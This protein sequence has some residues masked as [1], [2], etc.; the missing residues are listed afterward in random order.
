MQIVQQGPGQFTDFLSGYRKSSTGVMRK[1]TLKDLVL[2][3]AA[4]LSAMAHAGG[5]TV[6]VGME[7]EG[8]AR[9]GLFDPK[10]QHLFMH[11]L[12]ASIIPPLIFK[13]IPQEIERKT[14]LKLTVSPSAVVHLLKNKKCYLRV[15]GQNVILSREK[16]PALRES[17]VETWHERE[18]LLNSSLDDLDADLVAEFMHHLGRPGE[19]ERILHRPYGL[20][21]YRDGQP[22]LTRAAAYLF[23][24]DP[25]RWHPRPGVEF[26]RFEGNEK[27]SGS[28]YNVAERLRIE[29]PIMKLIGEMERIMEARIKERVILRDLFFRE[30]FAYPSFAWRE[31]LTNA[32]AHRDYSLEGSAVEVWMFDDRLE[33]R[34]PGR[35]PGPVK[36]QQLLRQERAHYS[37]NPLISRVLTDRGIMRSMGEG[38]SR[39]FREM[40]QQGLNPPE[41][42]E[43]G[44]FCCLV[45]R[46]TP[47]LDESTLAWLE[48]FSAH[49]LN[50]RQKRILTYARVHGLVFSSSDYQRFG[51]DRD[52]AYA[53]IKDL[54]K[55]GIV[56]LLKKHGKV[57]RVLEGE[58]QGASLPGLKWVREALEKKGF[59]TLQ[60][61]KPPK[62][63][64]RRKALAMLRELAQ[65][66]YFTISGKGK[67]TKYQPT[68]Q[69]HLL[70]GEK[71]PRPEI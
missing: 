14:F 52:T 36:I 32:I 44:N 18:V 51:V 57:Y 20:I 45:F 12:E 15:G 54:V 39:I 19:T 42:K 35:L 1:R 46:N 48:R 61:L 28:E 40:D 68:E 27:R 13:A 8:E 70:L 6:F 55:R 5:G 38:L 49:D 33:I 10:A 22:L 60:D 24:K 4:S 37:R 2:D 66:G 34:S 53:E 3:V 25:L 65:Q 9:G 50:P 30:K 63:I 26:V 41:L 71:D 64:S 62:S 21:D 7:P 17:R 11:L 31:A 56:Q 59:F 47:L 58:D 69:L 29:A 16:I 23:A 43:E 67:G